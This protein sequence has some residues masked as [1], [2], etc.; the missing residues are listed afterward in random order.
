MRHTTHTIRGQTLRARLDELATDIGR[1]QRNLDRLAD[2]VETLTL[3]AEPTASELA[4]TAAPGD[5]TA[6]TEAIRLV[7]ERARRLQHQLGRRT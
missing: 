5:E 2:H 4:A 3:I 1:I 7:D 6:V